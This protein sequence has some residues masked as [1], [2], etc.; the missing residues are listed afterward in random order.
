MYKKKVK[1]LLILSFVILSVAFCSIIW[2]YINLNIS[3][4]TQ[5]QG[6]ITLQGHSTDSD[7][8]RYMVFILLPLIVFTASY[9]F[10]KKTKTKLFKELIIFPKI[11]NTNN[12]NIFFPTLI[13]SMFIILQFFSLTLPIGPI[14]TFHDGELFSVTKNVILN[15]TFFINTYTIHGFS[16]IFY[17]FIFWKLTGFETIGS[18]RLFFFFLNLL[19][20]FFCLI[21]SYQLIKFSNVKNKTI[22]FIL[23]SIILL[24]FSDYQVPINFSL[25]SYRDIYIILYL[26]FLTKLFTTNKESLI[27]YFFLGSIP[28]VALIMHIDTGVFLFVLLTSV[29]VYF[30]I[31]KKFKISS[32]IISFTLLSLV[33]LVLIFGSEELNNFIKNALTII[34]SMDYLHGTEY[35]QPFFS[36]GDDKNGMRA[37]RG[38]LLQL[39]AGLF[40]TYNLITKKNTMSNGGKVFFMFLFFLSFIMYKN[41]LGRSDSYHIRMSN[42]LPILINS[43]FILN[44]IILKIEKYFNSIN[45]SKINIVICSFVL[46][47]LV[48]FKDINFLK[49]KDY[50]VEVQK[51]LSLPNSH[52]IDENKDQFIKK[53]IK[54][55][56]EDKCFQNFTDDLILLYLINKPSCTKFV[57]SWL[58]SPEHLQDEYIASLKNSKPKYIVYNSEYFKVDG[59]EMSER[60]Q[61]VD[62]FIQNNYKFFQKINTYDILKIEN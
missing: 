59:I 18:G 57:A 42:D 37:T 47:T 53:Y 8:L 36:I 61:K 23:F 45:L 4:I 16:D 15:G 26:I 24:S 9:Y 56:A 49:I 6:T 51:L 10:F 58:A 46:C 20:K 32:Q 7:T 2:K 14:D 41:A 34:V 35:P 31:N 30:I 39:S 3:N 48:F 52:F 17:P 22:F 29:L 50:P 40:V 33:L 12:Y 1:N 27:T 62:K 11:L 43:F 25:F 28:P 44:L 19:I 5:A 38:L 21:L 13:L 54:I 60:L 55:S